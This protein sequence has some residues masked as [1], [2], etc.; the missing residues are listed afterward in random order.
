L[1]TP[2]EDS[3]FTCS[4]SHSG[5]SIS[6]DS[7]FIVTGSSNGAVIVMNTKTGEKSLQIEEIYEDE[8]YYPVIACEWQPRGS[9]FATADQSGGLYFWKDS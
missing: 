8:H 6:P 7:Q 3:S 1:F 9:M 5:I 2:F 4:S